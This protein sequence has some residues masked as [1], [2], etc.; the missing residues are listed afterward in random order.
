MKLNIGGG[1]KRFDGFLNVDLDP[2]TKP[3]IRADI[4]VDRLPVDDSTVDEVIAHH[5]F[6]HLGGDTFFHCLQELYRVCQNGAV[7]DV[8]VPHYRHDYFYGDPSHVRPISLE[9]MNRF[10]KKYNDEE[11]A[12]N[13]GTMPFAYFYGVDF[14]VIE[15]EYKI[16]D[17]FKNQFADAS[18]D[19]V[20]LFARIYNNVISEIHFK[21][22]VR[23]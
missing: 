14:E 7:I 13:P 18:I 9:M 11:L 8:H 10:S 21:M 4:G 20:N 23:K 12:G 22:V 17:W 1:H 15:H 3:D 19:Q 16:E 2:G 5:I 6:E